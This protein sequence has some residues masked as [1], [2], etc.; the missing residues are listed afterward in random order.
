MVG[1]FFRKTRSRERM[2]N[3]AGRKPCPR[4]QS[5]RRPFDVDATLG[6]VRPLT[7]DLVVESPIGTRDH[8]RQD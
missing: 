1:W 8:P 5:R 4:Q 6:E 2:K 7:T 3:T